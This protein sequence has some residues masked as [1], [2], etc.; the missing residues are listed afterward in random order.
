MSSLHL[1]SPLKREREASRANFM[2]VQERWGNKLNCVKYAMRNLYRS[3]KEFGMVWYGA[4]RIFYN[5]LT[6]IPRRSLYLILMKICK[7][8]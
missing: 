7:Q 4:A 6:V 5:F 2:Q 3:T 8:I 1:I